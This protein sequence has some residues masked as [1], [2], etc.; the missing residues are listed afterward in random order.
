SA[1]GWPSWLIA[2]PAANQRALVRSGAIHR[3]QIRTS[4]ALVLNKE[5]IGL[6]EACRSTIRNKKAGLTSAPSASSAPQPTGERPRIFCPRC[7]ARDVSA[8]M[9]R[10]QS[11]KV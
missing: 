4:N 6:E 2:S 3:P 5:Q 1:Y 10:T 8:N 9:L 7:V 11:Q